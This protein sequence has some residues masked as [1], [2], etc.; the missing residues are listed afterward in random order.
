M[1][2]HA[3]SYETGWNIGIETEKGAI[4][5]YN[6]LNERRLFLGF[7]KIDSD[8]LV[9]DD[10]IQEILG[11]SRGIET[12]NLQPIKS[13][14]PDHMEVLK[15]QVIFTET[16]LSGARTVYLDFGTRKW[17]RF[18]GPL[19]QAGGRV[20]VDYSNFCS[21]AYPFPLLKGNVVDQ[22]YYGHDL[23]WNIHTIE[24][25]AFNDYCQDGPTTDPVAIQRYRDR[26]IE[27]AA[28]VAHLFGKVSRVNID[29]GLNE[30][31]TPENLDR[32]GY[33]KIE[34]LRGDSQ[35]G[36]IWA[37]LGDRVAILTG[38]QREWRTVISVLTQQPESP[39]ATV[40]L[41]HR[42]LVLR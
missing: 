16:D 35:D 14:D 2:E 27:L 34:R 8:I 25:N 12:D 17:A 21:Y 33:Q 31:L 22:I 7:P 39:E 38:N 9:P 3:R 6:A 10:M 40:K 42:E 13:L 29:F 32:L 20:W 18:M 15:N 28:K 1:A 41:I 30:V 5:L 37:Q 19:E 23:S 26:F 11:L 24:T 36:A 4:G